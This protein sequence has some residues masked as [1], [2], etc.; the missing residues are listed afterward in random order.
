MENTPG[1]RDIE[2][3]IDR[4]IEVCPFETS[5]IIRC[6]IK[7]RK[8]VHLRTQSQFVLLVTDLL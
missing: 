1:N 8:M 3:P 7:T 6:N 5:V 4:K 2:L